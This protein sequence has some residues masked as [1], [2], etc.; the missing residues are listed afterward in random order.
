MNVT[1][2]GTRYL[3]VGANAYV[4]TRITMGRWNTKTREM[5][6][7]LKPHGKA[8]ARVAMAAIARGL[9]SI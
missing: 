8:Y 1:I 4:Y 7:Q 9:A 6:R 3:I 2:E 5:R